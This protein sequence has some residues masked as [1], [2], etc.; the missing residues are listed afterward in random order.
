MKPSYFERI[1]EVLC[2]RLQEDNNLK[3]VSEEFMKLATDQERIRFLAQL[4]SVK[5]IIRLPGSPSDEKSADQSR[6]LRDEGNKFFKAKKFR[7]SI[8]LYTE[9]LSWAPFPTDEVSDSSISLAFANRS[10]CLFQLAKYQMCLEDIRCAFRYG[11]PNEL[12]YK[13]YDR[14][15]QCL[16][17]VGS[18]DDALE[19]FIEA[20]QHLNVSELNAKRR[21]QLASEIDER[22]LTC[23]NRKSNASCLLDDP[24]ELVNCD[25]SVPELREGKST[26]YPSLSEA[27]DVTYASDR[28]RFIVAKRD[29][30]PGDVI[31]VEKPYASVLL[32]ENRL[33]HCDHC[34]KPTLA[35]IPCTACHHAL[36]CNDECR[37]A[38]LSSYHDVECRI[39]PV[40]SFS[41]VDK[42]AI[43]AVRAVI[44]SR[45][46][47]VLDQAMSTC[48][49]NDDAFPGDRNEIYS[50]DSYRAICTLVTHAEHRTVHDLFRRSSIAIFLTRCLQYAGFFDSENPSDD[51]VAAVGGI[52]LSHLQSFP[53]N[54]HE[55]SEFDLVTDA[56]A[57]S[58][59][60]E[61]GAGIYATLSLFNHS[62]NPAVTRNFYGDTC[63]VRAIRSVRAGE[64]LSDNYGAVY[65]IQSRDERRSKLKP[66]Y[67]FVCGCEA[68]VN[69]WAVVYDCVF[70][71][72]PLAL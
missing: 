5:E 46:T 6:S 40:L 62:C 51:S 36:Y 4:D 67:Y 18:I 33:N 37:K 26:N 65:A 72:T 56:V 31:L 7:N 63:V 55:V 24:T 25:K 45:C 53:C 59:P 68:C 27:C 16:L 41:G 11:Y 21:Q 34:F 14:R 3:K 28:G 35:P 47:A 69:D 60:H 58:V 17:A 13:L 8:Q 48:Y 1:F 52:L 43:L 54:A 61:L 44:L 66:Q 49:L 15:G 19:S 29:I 50:A 71:R 23:G 38:A 70:H 10:A 42:F 39:R 64:E 22:I 20:K 30:F 9:S 12:R 2:K 57:T 32:A